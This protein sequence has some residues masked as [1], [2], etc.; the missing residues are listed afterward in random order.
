MFMALLHLTSYA[1]ANATFAAT[2]VVHH[3][4]WHDCVLLFV[5]MYS[6]KELFRAKMQSLRD[7]LRAFEDDM[8]ERFLALWYDSYIKLTESNAHLSLIADSHRQVSLPHSVLSVWIR[9]HRMLTHNTAKADHGKEYI[10]KYNMFSRWRNRLLEVRD[11]DEVAG[12]IQTRKMVQKWG[13][14][15]KKAATDE[16]H[17]EEMHSFR[18]ARSIFGEWHQ[19]TAESLASNE[20]HVRLATTVFAQWKEKTARIL[21][22]EDG[23]AERDSA[24]LA[25]SFLDIMLARRYRNDVEYPD[26]ADN[27]Y[28]SIIATR[29]FGAW[30]RALD[31]KRK[32]ETLEDSQNQRLLRSVFGEWDRRTLES[33][34]A[35]NF[36]VSMPCRRMLKVWKLKMSLVKVVRSKNVALVGDA[37]KTWRL[38]TRETAFVRRQNTRVAESVLEH[39][40]TASESQRHDLADREQEFIDRRMSAQ[41]STLFNT[42]RAKSSVLPGMTATA[43]Q[44]YGAQIATRSLDLLL[45]RYDR[46]SEMQ[47][48][49]EA[50]DVKTVLNRGIE[51][52][53]LAFVLSRRRRREALL[54][55]FVSAR[56]SR[57]KRSILYAWED[58]FDDSRDIEARADDLLT[59]KNH[60]LTAK[61]FGAWATRGR[62]NLANQSLSEKMDE[63]SALHKYFTVYR[64]R[65]AETQALAV[66]GV[67]F[68]QELTTQSVDQIFRVWR[69]RLT[70]IGFKQRSAGAFFE[71]VETARKKAIW[72]NWKAVTGQQRLQQA[73]EEVVGAAERQMRQLAVEEQE[74]RQQD[75]PSRRRRA[76]S[77]ATT[78]G[79]FST[80]PRLNPPPALY[81]FPSISNNTGAAFEIIHPAVS[82]SP[83]PVYDMTSP[84]LRAAAATTARRRTVQGQGQVTPPGAAAGSGYPL[85]TPTRSRTRRPVPM[86]SI[87]RWK[88]SMKTMAPANAPPPPPPFVN[89]P[90]RHNSDGAGAAS[91]RVVD[92][93]L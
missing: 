6:D 42:W 45:V 12:E 38:K 32:L 49:A 30:K 20:Y 61:L 36:S 79:P 74:L 65:F 9:K 25:S 59:K 53:K 67:N 37:L 69:I 71:R 2:D 93:D 4:T 66:E 86:T 43:E 58:R 88:L 75:S 16:N 1:N 18:L 92:S 3:R 46:N 73:D 35:R 70:K 26:Q 19:A 84:T 33:C 47:T 22:R 48:L 82:P 7:K 72:K 91:S 5:K 41:A 60:A 83:P 50:M 56:D 63:D 78:M 8:R 85:E 64:S 14:R 34:E 77:T 44:F 23:V 87:S 21:E 27:L 51:R 68:K 54:E 24:V 52:W 40:Y 62:R 90:G 76:S 11:D 89:A 29:H 81:T 80:V 31:F 17:A 55:D 10:A 15:A 39:W 13:L 57:L 28:L